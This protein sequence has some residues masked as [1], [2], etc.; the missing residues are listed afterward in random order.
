MEEI[1]STAQTLLTSVRCLTLFMGYLYSIN[2]DSGVWHGGIIACGAEASLG[3]GEAA[4]EPLL[5]FLFHRAGIPALLSCCSPA[6]AP[7]MTGWG[8]TALSPFLPADLAGAERRVSA[9]QLRSPQLKP[10]NRGKS[11]HSHCWFF[12]WLVGFFK[13]RVHAVFGTKT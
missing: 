2:S 9:P 6:A 12:V 4:R 8:Q 11:V 3:R 7:S 1:I 13:K 5:I 10:G